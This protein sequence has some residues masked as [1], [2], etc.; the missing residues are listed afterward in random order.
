MPIKSIIID[1]KQT[2]A[3]RIA[4]DK[5]QLDLVALSLD[6][7]NDTEP[8]LDIR[9]YINGQLLQNLQSGADW[10]IK[11]MVVIDN[12][13]AEQITIELEEVVQWVKSNVKH[14][15]IEEMEGKEK[16]P[17]ELN[18]KSQNLYQLYKDTINEFKMIDKHFQELVKPEN[19]H[20]EKFIIEEFNKIS[21]LADLRY[22]IK[23]AKALEFYE[24]YKDKIEQ[25]IAYCKNEMTI[26]D[27]SKTIEEIKQ[28]INEHNGKIGVLRQEL[29]NNKIDNK[30]KENKTIN[31][32][33]EKKAKYIAQ[34][35]I[36]PNDIDQLP[37]RAKDDSEIVKYVLE[38]KGG[39]LQYTGKSIKNDKKMV[40]LAIY[41]DSQAF[42]HVSDVL[43]TNEE[44]VVE[45]LNKF[46]E[47]ILNKLSVYIRN[48]GKVKLWID[49]YT[50]QKQVLLA[51]IDDISKLA[52]KLASFELR[53]SDIQST[54]NKTK[55][56]IAE[57][58]TL[59]PLYNE[60]EE[61]RIQRISLDRQYNDLRN[62]DT[63]IFNIIS[64]TTKL[65][66]VERQ[67]DSCYQKINSLDKKMDNIPLYN[68]LRN[69]DISKKN[70]EYL[71][72][73]AEYEFQLNEIINQMN[74]INLSL[75]NVDKDEIARINGKIKNFHTTI[76]I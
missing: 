10:C 1:N 56:R 74:A 26:F 52:S 7:Q 5:V 24:I 66:Q 73:L 4:P 22:Q 23:N 8:N 16:Q 42:D 39:L 30:I 59:L 71:W 38:Q 29:E 72:Y 25:K 15:L 43:K 61:L 50:V 18:K 11:K 63:N 31:D 60:F 17:I 3:K 69:C 12:S 37:G 44:F 13:D 55:S 32:R 20:E 28:L 34:L 9:L 6:E 45:C 68:K 47:V 19:S 64:N 62:Q 46:W 2:T 21:T 48:T 35:K 27:I 51:K 41:Q 75:D 53:K 58:S 70:D 49:T 33:T 57:T 54:I 76:Y 65:K 14:I 36:N 67:R 40:M